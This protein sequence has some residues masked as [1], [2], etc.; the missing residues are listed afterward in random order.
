MVFLVG[1][2]LAVLAGL[3]VWQAYKNERDAVYR[4]LGNTARAT[5]ALVEQRVANMEAL[6]AGI[7]AAGEL[8]RDD[9]EAFAIRAREATK[10]GR[11]WFVVSTPDGQQL[12]NTRAPAGSPLPL[13]PFAPDAFE[14]VTSGRTYVSDLIF[15]PVVKRPVVFVSVGLPAGPHPR[16]F[17]SLAASPEELAEGTFVSSAPKGYVFG[18]ID[19]NGIILARSASAES[20]VGRAPSPEVAAA[21]RIG[22]E[23]FLRS[24]TLEG[25]DVLGAVVPVP[26][27]GWS[28][29]AGAPQAALQTSARRLIATG[30]LTCLVI[31]VAATG[32]AWWISR[33]A[34]RDVDALLADTGKIA[35]GEDLLPS[36]TALAE[37]SAIAASLRETHR[38]LREQLQERLQAE[39]ALFAAK[40]E[41][42]QKVAE[43]TASLTEL[44]GQMEEFNY[45]VSHD[46]RGPLRSMIGFSRVV[47]EDH[48]AALDP[49]AKDH[50]QRVVSS[51][52]RMS[53]MIEDL[54]ALSRVSREQL[55]LGPV[56][57]GPLVRDCVRGHPVLADQA[58]RIEII[59]PL[60]SVLGHPSPIQQ[61]MI[62][63]LVNALK[64]V[65]PGVEP[66][67]RVFA[68]PRGGFFRVVVE[69]NGIGIDPA[70][71]GRLFKVFER[72]Q[73]SRRFAGTGIGLSIV[74]RAVERLGGRVGVESDGQSGSRFWMELRPAAEPPV[75]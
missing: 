50:L 12:I 23:T 27:I 35:A 53:Q 8:E 32:V 57:L 46:L 3:L 71:H 63:L 54:L 62:N 13:V 75:V 66:R 7:V 47:L 52:E 38:R 18:V 65:R 39:A 33:S 67:V 60:P 37:T 2:S 64:F 36:G 1:A 15:G 28:I 72:L 56:D 9:I 73:P 31:L 42:E 68:E 22:R 49:E 17:L 11:R 6:L 26:R 41:L 4:E 30:L 20:F 51:G 69:D 24:R 21:V 58:R 70:H 59:D 40:A 25:I 44:L 29:A 5:A 16:Y 19:R 34:L 61:A 10:P 74:R 14:V 43:R 48:G 45:G 55:V